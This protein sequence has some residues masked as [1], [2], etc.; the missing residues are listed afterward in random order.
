MAVPSV[1]GVEGYQPPRYH[2]ASPGITFRVMA[3]DRSVRQTAGNADN[4]VCQKGLL[5]LAGRSSATVDHW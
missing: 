3:S 4:L 2:Q 1:R 5:V